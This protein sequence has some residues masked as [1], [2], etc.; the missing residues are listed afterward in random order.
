MMSSATQKKIN[1]EGFLSFVIVLT[2]FQQMPVIKELFYWYI[3]V[4]EYLFFAI[5]V[6]HSLFSLITFS[7]VTFIKWLL[8]IFINSLLISILEYIFGN[9]TIELAFSVSIPLGIV[10]CGLHSKYTKSQYSRLLLMYFFYSTIMGT[11]NIFYYADGFKILQ[12]YAVP[13]KNQIGPLLGIAINIGIY[14]LFYNHSLQRLKTKKVY[15]LISLILAIS[16][17]IAIRNRS[18]LFSL[19][20]VQLVVF[21]KINKK[22]FTVKKVVIV[23][24][25]FVLFIFS[26][27]FGI[28]S[29]FY[30]Y[31]WSSFFKNYDISSIESISAGRYNTYLEAIQ[32][33][34]KYPLFGQLANN[35]S[36]QRIPHNYLLNI[37]VN[38]GLLL[39]LPLSIFYIYLWYFAIR[40]IMCMKKEDF[41]LPYVIL[42]FSLIVSLFEYTYP[43]GPGVSQ[44]MLWFVLG[45]FIKTI[46]FKV[47]K[48]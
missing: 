35:V 14:L 46:S 18:G 27:Y 20:I 10:S 48:Y 44:I 3:R 37:W 23:L 6:A 22:S 7:R 21:V 34:L 8:I 5:L 26:V 38:Y 25:I 42:L 45:R 16:S 9:G 43:Y 47:N 17:L 13:S 1:F 19:L 11:L 15:L 32:Y 24:V 2:I 41:F 39:S 29:E 31:I 36:F 12:Y 4:I 40:G 33:I 28:W 30:D